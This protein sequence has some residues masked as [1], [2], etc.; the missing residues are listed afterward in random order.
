MTADQDATEQKRLCD[1]TFDQLVRRAS[2]RAASECERNY[3]RDIF[4]IGSLR[5]QDSPREETEAHLPE[6]LNKLAPVAFGGEFKVAP[7]DGAAV[8]VSLQWSCYYR[9]FPT[10]EQQ[11]NHFQSLSNQ[12]VQSGTGVPRAPHTP[13]VPVDE[14]DEPSS[15]SDDFELEE[16]VRAS[17]SGRG[18]RDVLM[19]RFRKI[20]CSASGMI[21]LK[22]AGGGCADISDLSSAV[23]V[24]LARA[25]AVVA[26][27][28]ES[29]RTGDDPYVQ[30]QVP[31]S[32]LVSDEAYDLFQHGLQKPVVPHWK[33][34]IRAD[35]RPDSDDPSAVRLSISFA[36]A[37]GRQ[38]SA[39][40]RDHPSLEA[41]LFDVGADFEFRDCDVRPFEV[42]L[43]PKGFRFDR[44]VW[45][46]PFNCAINSRTGRANG[47]A[48]THAPVFEQ[49]RLK[50]QSS[51]SAP[52][53][54]LA[55]DPLP[56]LDSILAAMEAYRNEWRSAG[57][58]YEASI[59]DWLERHVAEFNA[60]MDAFEG[61]ISR[62]EI[63]R[64]L[65][66]ADANIRYAFQLTN[67]TFARVGRPTGK[68]EWRLFQIVFLV[69]QIPGLAALSD[70]LGSVPDDL[71]RA[72]IIYFPT[73]GGKTEAYLS[74][75]AFHCFFDRLRGKT[76]GV[77]AWTRFP[78]RLLT[79]QQTQRVADAISVA[80]L[81]RRGQTD[82]RLSGPEVAG[83][84]VGYFV[85][86]SSTPNEL[87]NA[88]RYRY[89]SG[90]DVATWAAANDPPQ[91]Q[92]WRRLM[93][94]PSCRTPTI[95][96]ELDADHVRVL[97]RCTN[98]DCL[99][100]NG[101][102]PIYV[103]D[104]E[105][106]R[107]LPSVLV[108]TI[109]KLAGIGNQRKFSLILG[110]VDGY[111]RLHGYY[112]SKCCQKD[113]D[114][115]GLVAKV[116]SGLS[117]PTL[118]VQDELHLL[119]EG[120][121]TFDGHYET[122]VREILREFSPPAHL[123][124]IASSA[125][126]ENFGRQIEHLYGLSATEA[127]IFPGPGPTL[128]ASFYARTQDYPQRLY[129]GLIPHNKTIFN[130]VL[131]IIEHYHLIIQELMSLPIGSANPFGGR[132]S[133]GTKDWLDLLDLYVT[134]L[135]YF[136]SSRDLHSIHTDLDGHVSPSLEG[137]GFAPLH[138]AELTGSTSTDE[139]ASTLEYVARPKG[140]DERATA[141]L[142]TNMVSHGVDIDRFNAMFFY[143]MPRQNAEYIQA[144]SR[145]GRAHVGMV[146]VCHHPARERDQS[147]YSVFQK[148]HEYLG[149]LVEPV[150]IN[151]WATF[152]INRTLPGLFMGVLLQVL[153]N[154][155]DARAAGQFYMVDYVRKQIASGSIRPEDFIPLLERAYGVS[156]G[157]DV[158]RSGFREE[159]RLR[160]RQFLDQLVGAGPNKKFVS[161]VLIP[162]PMRS[163]RDVDDPIP[164]MLDRTGTLWAGQSGN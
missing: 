37:T 122:F 136:L 89:A 153:A 58:E 157:N 109:D 158:A 149:Q 129:I 71:K 39:A 67:E 14:G 81:V 146:F 141:V 100:P 41:F 54:A 1:Y 98:T 160:V 133:P 107:Y 90:D 111:C 85:G 19:L 112:K 155:A 106:Y 125:T 43:A 143:G 10:R 121:G 30:V 145:V 33:W 101:R 21:E 77:T 159:I 61:E 16:K 88:D 151:R 137:S 108:G 104:N 51:P 65:I 120:L 99:F 95:R 128:S 92:S 105:I 115:T 8:E 68:Y 23:D 34:D 62:F 46:R 156:A 147:H 47:F 126:I 163:L 56:V 74:V 38:L 91:L 76:A 113:C 28:P 70:T 102:I 31:A 139:V 119:K 4:F 123:K 26:E 13:P 25:A 117:G 144:S 78:L 59:P 2:G 17:G 40:K 11:L 134:S 60:D 72:D 127:R 29:I 15:E 3:P 49:A 87:I 96:V 148:Y 52:F 48:T 27:D 75:I 152:S 32:A 110:S 22:D 18:Q 57:T 42:E 124:I 44:H 55:V 45:S 9:V 103:I 142:A 118:F 97:H 24:E 79:L 82:E 36:N 84:G 86:R 66:A 73:G 131:E 161:D 138:I 6:L 154:R 94:C 140:G 93:Y 130:T 7:T 20:K 135:T 116:P 162:R 164:V 53:K 114:G 35:T 83:F 12:A 50:T 150:A 132:T 63:G 69:S 80:D 5:S 64:N